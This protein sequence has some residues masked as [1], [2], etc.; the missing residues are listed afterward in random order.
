[1][2]FTGL[3][4]HIVASLLEQ[5]YEVPVET[6]QEALDSFVSPSGDAE[7][8]DSEVHTCE[9]T[10]NG[11]TGPYICGKECKNEVGGMWYCGT[12]N[13]GHYKS[14]LSAE[15][16]APV[17]PKGKGKGKGKGKIVA[18]KASPKGKAA[19]SKSSALVAKITK[20]QQIDFHEVVP[21]SGLWIEP[22][23]RVIADPETNEVYGILAEDNETILELTDDALKYAE[24]H[25]FTVREGSMPTPAP[26]RKG[27]AS[28]SKGK[29]VAAKTSAAPKG[30]APVAKAPV[31]KGK[32]P[33]GK[34]PVAKAP[35]AKGKAIVAKT[36]APKGK[37]PVAKGK[38]PVAKG[39]APAAPKGKAPAAKGKVSPK[40][41]GKS[42]VVAAPTEE[43]DEILEELQQ[44]LEDAAL[45][46]EEEPDVSEI[47]E[48]DGTGDVGEVE[49]EVDFGAE[50]EGEVE[51]EPEVEEIAEE[52][53]EETPDIVEDDEGEAIED[54]E[55]EGEGEVEADE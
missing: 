31:A 27:K 47:V 29:A 3:A 35:A 38:A 32:A 43:D 45:Q 46:G 52:D 16:K 8:A 26:K 28:V 10:V 11:Q 4:D 41:K 37:A 23:F 40:G 25:G 44:G 48:E 50:G 1:M 22:E 12:E 55:G 30:K 39:K 13:S 6:I 24:V 5:S 36:P 18:S 9:R 34:A 19:K 17:A 15:K 7:E 49:A 33:K 51:E 53:G 14:A 21:E 54:G 42:K 2:D 20:M